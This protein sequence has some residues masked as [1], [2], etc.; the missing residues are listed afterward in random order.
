MAEQTPEGRRLLNSVD[1]ELTRIGTETQRSRNQAIKFLRNL[2]YELDLRLDQHIRG[3][4][5]KPKS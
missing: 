2:I 5:P 4:I 1:D 3:Q